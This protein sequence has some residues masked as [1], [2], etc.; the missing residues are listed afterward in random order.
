VI[1]FVSGIIHCSTGIQVPLENLYLM[2]V[3]QTSYYSLNM[4]HYYNVLLTC[5]ITK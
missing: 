2:D 5:C 3:S 4:I 1:H